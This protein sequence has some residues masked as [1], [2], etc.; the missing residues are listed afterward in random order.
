MVPSAAVDSRVSGG[1]ILGDS[2]M[3]ANYN[4][5]AVSPI[6]VL[7]FGWTLTRSSSRTSTAPTSVCA[8]YQLSIISFRSLMFFQALRCPRKADCAGAEVETVNEGAYS[9]GYNDRKLTSTG[10]RSTTCVKSK[11]NLSSYPQPCRRLFAPAS[12]PPE[13]K[14]DEPLGR[15]TEI[16]QPSYARAAVGQAN[17]V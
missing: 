2:M 3:G 6:E 14:R 9:D 4:P 10:C 16:P 12:R 11:T 7:P 17:G 5:P 8:R 15:R 1:R 13:T